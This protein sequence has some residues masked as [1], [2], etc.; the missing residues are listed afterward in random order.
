MASKLDVGGGQ[1]GGEPFEAHA[2]WVAAVAED[3]AAHKGRSLVIAGS[4]Q[5]AVVHLLAHALNQHLE[6]VGKT[7][8]YLDAMQTGQ[9]P[10]SRSLGELAEAMNDGQVECLL[11]LGGNPAYHGGGRLED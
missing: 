3:L 2:H 11:I 10:A 5:P 1:A 6:N 9:H 8:S 7:V 4:R